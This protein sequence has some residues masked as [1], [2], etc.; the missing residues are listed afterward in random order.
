MSQEFTCNQKTFSNTDSIDNYLTLTIIILNSLLLLFFLVKMCKLCSY[1]FSYSNYHI[2]ET[3]KLYALC[4]I[5]IMA[6]ILVRKTQVDLKDYNAIN[7]G[8][9]PGTDSNLIGYYIINDLFGIISILTNN[10]L[11]LF[12]AFNW[13]AIAKNCD[14]TERDDSNFVQLDEV[15]NLSHEESI[16]KISQNNDRKKLHY[17]KVYFLYCFLPMLLILSIVGTLNHHQNDSWCI[18]INISI[19]VSSL[20]PLV[21]FG[22]AFALFLKKFSDSDVAKKVAVLLS[23]QRSG[24]SSCCSRSLPGESST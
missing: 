2:H 24:W 4:I 23:R 6:A 16:I 1:A 3:Y 22:F 18:I 5:N 14:F 11:L 20:I 13:L 19:I 12:N 8:N 15:E 21:V 10:I 17:A 7:Q 9:V